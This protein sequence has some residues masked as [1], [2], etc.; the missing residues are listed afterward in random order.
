MLGVRLLF[1]ILPFD[2]KF[3]AVSE[4]ASVF[5]LKFA[6]GCVLFS[7]FVDVSEAYAS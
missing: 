1:F 2:G 5:G 3:E 6:K 4:Y 7:L